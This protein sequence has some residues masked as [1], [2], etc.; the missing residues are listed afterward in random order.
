MPCLGLDLVLEGGLGSCGG[1]RG[2]PLERCC[3]KGF[4]PLCSS[5]SSA[6]ESGEES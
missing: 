6:Q 3:T 5:D 1:G 4:E 2:S